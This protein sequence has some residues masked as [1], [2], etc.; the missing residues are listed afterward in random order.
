MPD[1]SLGDMR[2]DEFEAAAQRVAEWMA[3]YLRDIEQHPVLARTP[4][5]WLREQLPAHAPDT[6]EDLDAVLA[7]LDRLIVP[8]TTHWNS[9]GFF[10]YFAS[11]SSAAG[12]LGEML[13]AAFNVNAMLWRTSP[14]ATELE[15]VV[16]DWLRRLLGLP[17]PLFGVINDTASSSTLYALA[18]A[19]ES[20][21][22]LRIRDA[23]MSG[24]NDLPQLR[25]YASAEAHSSVDKACL[26]L[27]LGTRGV[28][29]IAVDDAYRIDPGALRRALEEDVAA[30]VRPM[31]VV[32]TV[33]TTSTTSVDSVR[34][35]A[36]VCGEHGVWLHV[37]AA[38]GGAAAIVPELA[39]VLGGAERGDSIVVNPHKWLF[40]PID[41]SVLWTRR[42]DVLRAAFSLVPE[43]LR[44]DAR[45]P[46]DAPDLMDYG[47][48][49]GR[50]FRA[51][52]LWLVLRRFGREGIVQLIRRHCEMARR[53]AALVE[54][55]ARWELMAPAPLSVVCLRAHPSGVTDES[56]LDAL[57][58][59][60]MRRVNEA[61]R[62]FLSHT[63]VRDR[64]V[65]RVAF[66]HV[67][68]TESQPDALWE[69]LE[70]AQA[71]ELS[72]LSASGAPTP[73]ASRPASPS[74]I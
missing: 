36:D 30:G 19:R 42:P 67:R 33:G 71:A 47:M 21:T 48:S 31:A 1:P 5:G 46:E 23:G 45:A 12:V 64:Y 32:A 34:D 44:S 6:A 29:R 14:A 35:V 41:C 53:L 52:K 73:P 50:R 22:D 8:A 39:W 72:A 69:E 49:L 68:A 15:Q 17:E 10:A 60:V 24:R 51:L 43:Y 55:S 74:S 25:V 20:L 38:Y 18:A 58:E 9:P 27:G 65:I 7:D 2:V 57:S 26:V 28:R 40:T 3:A 16:I 11:S 4:P 70:A 62:F 56:Q 59:R 61:G 66:G 37:D 63:R 54:A 13:S